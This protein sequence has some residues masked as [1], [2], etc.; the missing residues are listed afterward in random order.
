MRASTQQLEI[1][2][3]KLQATD[4]RKSYAARL[5]RQALVNTPT[6]VSPNDPADSS[7]EHTHRY[8]LRLLFVDIAAPNPTEALA[9]LD[10][11]EVSQELSHAD[12]SPRLEPTATSPSSSSPR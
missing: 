7:S 6:Y 8:T 5:I 4:G 3:A 2:D 11:L 10:S 12:H 9:M 1:L